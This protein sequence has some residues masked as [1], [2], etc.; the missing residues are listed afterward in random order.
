MSHSGHEPKKAYQVTVPSTSDAIK[1]INKQLAVG[2]ISKETARAAIAQVSKV[3]G[4]TYTDKHAA[5]RAAKS[6]KGAKVVEGH[7]GMSGQ[8]K[9]GLFRRLFW[10]SR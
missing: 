4:V 9:E 3:K 8:F 7:I 5:R 6:V 1:Y 10:R 2:Q